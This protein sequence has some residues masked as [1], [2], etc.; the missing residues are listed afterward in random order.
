MRGLLAC[1]VLAIAGCGGAQSPSTSASPAIVVE[2]VGA[3][4]W[5]VLRYTLA[6]GFQQRFELTL[7]V[8]AATTLTNTVLEDDKRN[9]DFPGLVLHMLA[10]VTSVTPAGDAS[11][12]YE[13]EN[14]NVLEDVIDPSLRSIAEREATAIRGARSTATLSANGALS[15][16]HADS[17]ARSQSSQRWLTEL[18]VALGN[19]DVV[20]PDAPI[21]VGATWTVTSHPTRRDVHWTRVATYTLRART[22][23]TVDLEAT[24]EMTAGSQALRTEPNASIRLTSA[25]T[26]STV[27]ATLPLTKIAGESSSEATAELSYL[28]V[29]RHER[30]SSTTRIQSITSTRSLGD[31]AP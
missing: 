14:A 8:R 10:K 6:P 21:G 28:I 5:H 16:L 17:G 20:F 7:K 11:L 22:E 27:H 19:G 24:I 26:T 4:P 15:N 25:R 13:I 3:E 31:T 30:L 1:A 2:Q 12:T 9:L 18:E 29:R 23:T